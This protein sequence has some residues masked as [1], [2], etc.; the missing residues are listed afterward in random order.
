MN[1]AYS[2]IA[3]APSVS[4]TSA[5]RW[6]A[7]SRAITTPSRKSSSAGRRPASAPPWLPV[8]V[9]NN[10]ARIRSQGYAFTRDELEEGLSGV[11]VAIAGDGPLPL[12]TINLSGLTQRLS[13]SRLRDVADRMRTVAGD[14]TDA[15]HPNGASPV[16]QDG[17]VAP[18][19]EP[20]T[21]KKRPK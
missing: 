12:G 13:A 18:P 11:S 10:L 9:A 16:D 17:D 2:S 1:S 4:S 19:P 8:A 6:D 7:P 15:M 21:A 14:I 5:S 20:R 3:P